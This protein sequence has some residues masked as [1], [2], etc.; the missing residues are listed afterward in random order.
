MIQDDPILKKKA[1]DFT[2]AMIDFKK[3]SKKREKALSD[4][5]KR[6]LGL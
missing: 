4:L 5:E 1:K 3:A 6:K 2:K